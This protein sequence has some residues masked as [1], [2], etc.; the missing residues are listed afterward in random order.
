MWLEVLG[1][2]LSHRCSEGLVLG[3]RA[4]CCIAGSRVPDINISF[5]LTMNPPIPD[6]V[7]IFYFLSSS[8]L[9]F[10]SYPLWL[11]LDFHFPLVGRHF[12][13]LKS[14]PDHSS[15]HRNSPPP[16]SIPPVQ[17]AS[18]SGSLCIFPPESAHLPRQSCRPE[19]LTQQLKPTKEFLHH[20]RSF[21]MICQVNAKSHFGITELS[22]VL[23]IMP[24]P[25]KCLCA[26]CLLW[27]NGRRQHQL[28]LDKDGNRTPSKSP[29]HLVTQ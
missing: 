24:L 3:I 15:T 27:V 16:P 7:F 11:S 4:L 25:S 26:F 14:C 19:I 22:R 13:R 18:P 17:V 12:Y 21:L 10:L 28:H 23:T 29:H 8:H 20:T 6:I 9:V 5:H 1:R 2:H